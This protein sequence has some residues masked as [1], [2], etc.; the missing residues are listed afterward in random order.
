MEL[1]LIIILGL[2]IEVLLRNTQVDIRQQ[3]NYTKH[4]FT[5]EREDVKEES[6][7]TWSGV[8]HKIFEKH[9]SLKFLKALQQSN[10]F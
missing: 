7:Q 3:T 1:L 2:E 8:C 4:L 10:F 9:H 6:R 5:A